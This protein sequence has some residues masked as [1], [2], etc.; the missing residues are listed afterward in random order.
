MVDQF[1]LGAPRE[2]IGRVRSKA[3]MGYLF[4]I[5][6]KL[7]GSNS[8]TNA[9]RTQKLITDYTSFEATIV[10]NPTLEDIKNQISG[11]HPVISL[12]YGYDLNNPLHSY[13]RGGSSYH[14]MVLTGFD[15]EKQIL[16]ANDPELPGQLDY[17]YPYA[18][19][20]AS[21]RDF[22]HS[23]KKADGPPT[24]L[25]TKPKKLVHG[26]GRTRVY[27]VRGATKYLVTNPAVFKNHHW[28]WKL[29]T[30]VPTSELDALKTGASINE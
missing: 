8:D 25:Y 4:P 24:V 11:G 21:L 12:H 3:L 2:D 6:D 28:S 18:T 23:T 1:Y 14:M 29:V 22:N 10:R 26:I 20:M 9:T 15:D 17:A 5:E 7:F 19:I 27:L 30:A 16:Y 13:R